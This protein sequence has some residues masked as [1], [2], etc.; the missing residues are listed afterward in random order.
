[1]FRS[2]LLRSRSQKF[3]FAR[4]TLYSNLTRANFCARTMATL[5][6]PARDPN[7]LSNYNNWIC[8]HSIVNFEILFEQKKLVGNVIHRLRSTTNAET[9]EVILDSHHVN[10]G[11]VQVAGL[12]VKWELLPP[13]GP[14]GTALKIKLERPLKLDEIIDVNVCRI[15]EASSRPGQYANKGYRSLSKQQRNAPLSSG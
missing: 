15:A 2:F 10:I 13:L 6:N 4:S 14:Y 7:T 1:M 8:T 3:Y 12:T 11:D 5:I 9:K